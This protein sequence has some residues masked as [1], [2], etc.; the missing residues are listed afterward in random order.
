[1]LPR[2][3]MSVTPQY[4]TA[5][6]CVEQLQVSALLPAASA[7]GHLHLFPCHVQFTKNSFALWPENFCL[8]LCPDLLFKQ[9]AEAAL[10]EEVLHISGR[11]RD[12]CSRQHLAC[13]SHLSLS[14]TIH[15][16]WVSLFLSAP[17]CLC[18]CYFQIRSHIPP[19]LSCHNWVC[20]FH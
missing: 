17:A 9:R 19:S 4:K 12:V 5:R 6:C 16:I 11:F 3:G 13:W 10:G 8:G 20:S 15:I 14:H 7:R 1:M 18:T 2:C